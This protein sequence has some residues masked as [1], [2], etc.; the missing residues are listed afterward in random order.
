MDRYTQPG[1]YVAI[2]RGGRSLDQPP[3]HYIK[4]FDFPNQE[5]REKIYSLDLGMIICMIKLLKCQKNW[6][7]LIRQ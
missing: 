2:C 7:C 5:D 3:V 6:P 4:V 1:K